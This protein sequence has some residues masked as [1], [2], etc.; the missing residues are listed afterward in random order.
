M[1]V[2]KPAPFVGL[3]RIH[4]EREFYPVLGAHVLEEDDLRVGIA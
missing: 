1:V 4:T 3:F 2:E